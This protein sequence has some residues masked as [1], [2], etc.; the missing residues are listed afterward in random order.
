MLYTYRVMT[1]ATKMQQP[2]S[3]VKLTP[4]QEAFCNEFI[5]DLNIKQAAIRAGYSEKHAA[6]NAYTL[7]KNP[8][9]VQ[10]IA[11]LKSEQTKRTK[12]EADDILRRLVRIAENKDELV[13][14]KKK[15]KKKK[16][17]RARPVTLTT[18]YAKK[19]NI[20]SKPKSRG[21][22][23]KAKKEKNIKQQTGKKVSKP[24]HPAHTKKSKTKDK[25]SWTNIIKER[26]FGKSEAKADEPKIKPKIKKKPI[27]PSDKKK[28]KAIMKAEEARRARGKSKKAK[29]DSAAI[30]KAE[31]SRRAK[32]KED[33]PTGRSSAASGAYKKKEA[34]ERKKYVQG[35]VKSGPSGS[36]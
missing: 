19:K 24:K 17:I 28:D 6:N 29:Q 12:I 27:S 3:E 30:M 14:D 5:K 1:K 21:E 34:A 25:K 35:K 9:I 11:E 18:T 15:P 32:A 20:R 23:A 8:A 31:K 2:D 26:L 10:R 13:A 7:T 16:N 36:R 33:M 22:I 4:Q